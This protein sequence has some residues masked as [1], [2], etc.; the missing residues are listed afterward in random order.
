MFTQTHLKAL[1]KQFTQIQL[2]GVPF[3]DVIPFEELP[4]TIFHLH[5][6]I[7]SRLLF[8]LLC[9]CIFKIIMLV[10]E[11]WFLTLVLCSK[12]IRKR[13]TK[14]QFLLGPCVPL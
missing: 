9:K 10:S 8:A 12:Q 4:S 14:I 11:P 1:Q 5:T 6:L 3:W 2:Q 13:P 7:K